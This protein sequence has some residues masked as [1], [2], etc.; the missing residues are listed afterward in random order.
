MIA[1]VMIAGAVSAAVLSGWRERREVASVD[2]IDHELWCEPARGCT[3]DDD[4]DTRGTRA[5]QRLRIKMFETRYALPGDP[6]V[7][8]AGQVVPS[9]CLNYLSPP[10]CTEMGWPTTKQEAAERGVT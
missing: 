9:A 3:C 4:P 7:N 6:I 10:E 5:W 2:G 8:D 1:C